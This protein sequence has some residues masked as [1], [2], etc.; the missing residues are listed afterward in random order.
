MIHM[1]NSKSLSDRVNELLRRGLEF[2]K[3]ER[4]E[5]EAEKFFS[6]QDESE[7]REHIAYQKAA[8]ATLSRDPSR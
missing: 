3:R 1:K 5:Q 7:S 2:E 6:R 4:L 8:L